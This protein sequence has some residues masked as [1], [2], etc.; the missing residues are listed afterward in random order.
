MTTRVVHVYTYGS[1]VTIG[2]RAPYR[3]DRYTPSEGGETTDERIFADG[4]GD[5]S[6]MHLT[7]PTGYDAR[8]ASCWLGYAHTE[9]RHARLIGA[10]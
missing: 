7:Y 8:C 3:I 6:P 2:Y 1:A 5:M 10:S 9:A 4:P